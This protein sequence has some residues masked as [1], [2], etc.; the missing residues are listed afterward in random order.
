MKGKS[1]QRDIKK[2]Q[3]KIYLNAASI[4]SQLGRGNYIH[5]GLIIIGLDYNN[6]T[7]HNFMRLTN[8]VLV[9]VISEGAMQY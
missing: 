2:L 9:P 7:V 3:K 4:P 8:L 6:A 1:T 5:L